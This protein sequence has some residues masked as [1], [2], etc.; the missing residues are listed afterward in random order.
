MANPYFIKIEL[1]QEDSQGSMAG[2]SNENQTE[3]TE[4]KD[5][6]ASNAT[7]L[8]KRMVSY[9]AIKSTA[10]QVINYNISAVSLKTGANEYSQ[11]LQ[12]GYQIGTKLLDTGVSIGVGVATGTLPLMFAGLLMNG[13]NQLISYQQSV[14]ELN[15]KKYSEDISLGM[16]RVRAGTSGRRGWNT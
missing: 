11:R 4:T 14:D 5:I 3:K 7:K 1:P 16:Q 2:G 13:I 10:D 9:G 6:S 15:T 12:V 8:V